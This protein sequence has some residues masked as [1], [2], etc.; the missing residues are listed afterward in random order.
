MSAIWCKMLSPKFRLR[1]T[2]PTQEVRY[3]Q[4]TR[5]TCFSRTRISVCRSTF[6]PGGL[7]CQSNRGQAY[8]SQRDHWHC[9]SE[10]GE[11]VNSEIMG[12]QQH[13]GCHE[14]GRASC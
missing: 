3:A 7:S 9:P 8:Q 2:Q 1:K 11:S 14:I 4:K 12:R 13:L 10:D 5:I 6:R